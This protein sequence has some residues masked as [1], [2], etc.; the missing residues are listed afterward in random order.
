M[1][2]NRFKSISL[3]ILSI[4]IISLSLGLIYKVSIPKEHNLS[5][6]SINAQDTYLKKDINTQESLPIKTEEIITKAEPS[7]VE[8]K[9]LPVPEK[10]K[11]AE[12]KVQVINKETISV[13][14]EEEEEEDEYEDLEK[15]EDEKDEDEKD[16]D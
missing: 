16:E 10:E 13:E 2:L 14:N 4:S 1:N 12:Q 3:D 9:A 11:K 7:K 15:E 6:S 8:N 5:T